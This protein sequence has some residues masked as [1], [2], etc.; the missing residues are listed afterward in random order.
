VLTH[1]QWCSNDCS[2]TGPCTK[3]CNSTLQYIQNVNMKYAVM[4]CNV[5]QLVITHSFNFNFHKY[6][7]WHV[8][9]ML[10]YH[11][12]LMHANS[13]FP[14]SIFSAHQHTQRHTQSELNI[15]TSQLATNLWNLWH[16][17]LCQMLCQNS[18]KVLH[19]LNFI[20]KITFQYFIIIL[21]QA[22]TN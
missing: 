22:I 7:M 18:A 1:G 5:I 21:L 6:Y 10:K 20:K 11:I 8:N 15:T 9:K 4:S 13:T 2:S 19:W 16:Q 14:L 3:T 12:S 17:F